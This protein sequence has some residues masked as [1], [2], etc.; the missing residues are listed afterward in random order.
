MIKYSDDT[1]LLNLANTLK[2]RDRIQKDLDILEKL[3]LDN[4]KK[5]I[6]D[7]CRV[8][9]VGKK[10]LN[11]HTRLV[12]IGLSFVLPRKSWEVLTNHKLN[13]MLL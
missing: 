9:H 3:V 10:Q 5:F 2:E 8:L 13:I 12:E 4:I 1:K 6:K 11:I 7:K